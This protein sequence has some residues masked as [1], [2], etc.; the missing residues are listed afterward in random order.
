MRKNKREV[1]KAAEAV[2]GGG[3]KEKNA[4]FGGG[5]ELQPTY[6]HARIPGGEKKFFES[7]LFPPLA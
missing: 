1:G 4:F 5:P 7:F 3:G 6:M 2:V